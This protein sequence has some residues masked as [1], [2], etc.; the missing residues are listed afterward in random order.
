MISS[1]AP[2]RVGILGNPSDG[3]GGRTLALAVPQFEA[4]VTLEPA[5]RI[6]ILNGPDDLPV[7]RSVDDMVDHLDRHGYGTGAQLLAATVRTFVAVAESVGHDV[8]SGFRLSY[9]TTI[10]RQVGLGGSSALVVAALR[11]LSE[12]F[13]LELPEPVLPSVALRAETTQLGIAAGLQDRVVQTYGGLVAMDFSDMETDSR[14][15]V[16]HGTYERLDPSGLPPLFLGYHDSAAQPSGTYHEHL[17]IKYEAGDQVVREMLR[18]LAALVLEGRAALRWRDA[19]RFGPLIGK[20]MA[21]RRSLGPLPDVQVELA[22]LAE[23][24]GAHATF[25][26]SGGAIVG[27]YDGDDHFEAL[28]DAFAD[29]GADLVKL[30]PQSPGPSTTNDIGEP[31]HSGAG[32]RSLRGNV[33]TL[34]R[35]DR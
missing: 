10:P 12:H 2:A 16:S 6:E 23:A 14:F 1:A 21:L 9:D 24:T 18:E 31:G 13:R 15:G 34:G 20:N 33:V 35:G 4:T 30:E 28:A 17:R 11:C 3:Y 26:G 29:I 19:A 5:D 8:E 25:A 22:D 7:W 27:T 32:A